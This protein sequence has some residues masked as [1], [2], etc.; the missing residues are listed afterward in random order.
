MGRTSQRPQASCSCAGL[1]KPCA[2]GAHAVDG[3]IGDGVPLSTLTSLRETDGFHR[4]T[5]TKTLLSHIRGETHPCYAR[6]CI[7]PRRARTLPRAGSRTTDGP[8]R[9]PRA[10]KGLAPRQNLGF[11]LNKIG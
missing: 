1:Y 8:R 6:C 10:C 4:E 5:G 2:T 11:N 9:S 7:A 3:S